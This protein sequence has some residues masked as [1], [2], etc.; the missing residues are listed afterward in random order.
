MYCLSRLYERHVKVY[1]S[2]FC[3]TT[4]RDQY[5]LTQDEIGELCDV[6]LMYMGPGKYAEI[7]RIRPP[8]PSKPALANTDPTLGK[9]HKDV[10]PK[11]AVTTSKKRSKWPKVTHRGVRNRCKQDGKQTTKTTQREKRSKTKSRESSVSPDRTYY[12]RSERAKTRCELQPNRYEMC[13]RT[14]K[15]TRS[16]SKPKQEHRNEINY[17]NL[18]DG[19]CEDEV[20]SPPRKRP[21]RKGPGSF[22]SSDRLRSYEVQRIE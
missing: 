8:D 3:W 7:H 15:H 5:R 2:S 6:H 18:N 19:L 11:N 16:S 13:D 21:S 22:P 12:I 14:I 9:T 20:C 10:T 4:L 1:T 17:A